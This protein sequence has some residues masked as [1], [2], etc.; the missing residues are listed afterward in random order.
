[1]TAWDLVMDPVMVSGEHWVWD[2]QGA[3]FGIPLQN[4]WGWWLTTFVTFILFTWLARAAPSWDA[5]DEP[6]FERQ[7]VLS[8]AISGGSTVITAAQ[9]GLGGPA[10]VGIFVMLPWIFTAWRRQEVRGYSTAYL[11]QSQRYLQPHPE[12]LL[13]RSEVED[14]ENLPVQ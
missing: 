3:Y 14:K 12:D 5:V 13:P 1:M 2:V 11:R 9:L 7:A 10:L 8:Y 6:G 4:F